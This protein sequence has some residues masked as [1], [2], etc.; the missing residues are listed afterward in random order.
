M[1]CGGSSKPNLERPLSLTPS[2]ESPP[3][4]V[5]LP[6]PLPYGSARSR[7]LMK[8][9]QIL[10]SARMLIQLLLSMVL[11]ALTSLIPRA[12][13]CPAVMHVSWCQPRSA[14]LAGQHQFRSTT[15]QSIPSTIRLVAGIR[16]CPPL[17]SRPGSCH[18]FTT[19][20]AS[21][22]LSAHSVHS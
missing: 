4:T 5:V 11:D 18:F 2:L 22:T 15:L 10:P 21:I 12:T 13:P 19:I 20:Y 16:S 3:S 1:W 9:P 8:G 6:S 7:H 17:P 14:V